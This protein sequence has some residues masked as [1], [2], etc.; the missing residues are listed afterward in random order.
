MSPI[1]SRGTI[2]ILHEGF[3]GKILAIHLI[4]VCVISVAL[5]CFFSLP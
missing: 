5:G 4:G 2:L 1:T 3:G